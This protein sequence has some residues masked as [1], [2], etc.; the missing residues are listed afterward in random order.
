M[1]LNLAHKTLKTGAGTSLLIL[2]L[3]NLNLLYLTGL[4]TLVLLM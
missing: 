3:E 1:K 2:M 4:I